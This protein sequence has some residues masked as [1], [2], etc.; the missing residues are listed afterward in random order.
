MKAR[1]K[2]AKPQKT[3]RLVYCENCKW[4]SASDESF[5]AAGYG[6]AGLCCNPRSQNFMHNIKNNKFS[7][8]QSRPYPLIRRIVVSIKGRPKK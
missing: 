3:P 6:P 8:P 5:S 2:R 7:C 4:F 1:T